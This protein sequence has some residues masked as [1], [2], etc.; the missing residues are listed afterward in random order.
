M[1][2]FWTFN[3][4]RGAVDIPD[5]AWRAAAQGAAQ[6]LRA[7]G[8]SEVAPAIPRPAPD[9]ASFG[10]VAE[11]SLEERKVIALE[12]IAG[13]FQLWFVSIFEP[14]DASS[15]T[16]SMFSNWTSQMRRKRER[17]KRMRMIERCRFRIQCP[18]DAVRSMSLRM[19]LERILLARYCLVAVTASSGSPLKFKTFRLRYKL[20]YAASRLTTPLTQ[21]G[22]CEAPDWMYV[23]FKLPMTTALGPCTSLLNKACFYL[24]AIHVLIPQVLGFH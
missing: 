7:C 1:H 6:K 2:A 4:L 18:N 21:F 14:E 13:V 5:E 9:L 17:K 8:S 20:P 24:S 16:D 12:K 15:S 19:E 23:N 10:E 3:R 22:I 11:R